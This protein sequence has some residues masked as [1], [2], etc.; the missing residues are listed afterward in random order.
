LQSTYQKRISAIHSE[1]GI[2]ADY[3]R[4]R[5]L[6]LQ[7][8]CDQLV[9]AGKDI[10]EREQSMHRQAWQ[11]WQAMTAAAKQSKIELQLVSAYRS[12]EYQVNLF[13]KKLAAGQDI[14]TILKVNAAPG[15]SEH[16]SGCALDLNSPD[17]ECLEESFE[18]TDA[19]A[20]LQQHAV[21]FD[22]YLSFPRNNPQGFS[23]E[24]W[25]WCYRK[26]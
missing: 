8:E 3:A 24:P 14:K 7:L 10:F 26:K 4:S 19:F 25:H 21:A 15:F 6:S 12:V 17:G 22:F 16:H 18:Q 23:Y 11:S 5:D 13:K 20:W 1:L 9:S 2:P